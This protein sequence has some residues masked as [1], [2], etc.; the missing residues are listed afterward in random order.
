MQS[1]PD[2][3]MGLGPLTPG[4]RVA[5]VAPAG[6]PP[7]ALLERGAALL[8]DW[9]L[10]PV[11]FHS[12][13]ARHPRA[14]YLAGPD[15]RRAADLVAAWHD[16][17][18]TAIF[19]VRGGYGTVRVLD[20]LDAEAMATVAPKPVYGSSDITALHE[21]LR[22]RLDVPSWFAPM[23]ATADL[24][25]D[26]AAIASLRAAVFDG[27]AGRSWSAA[28][29][30]TLVPGRARGPLI[31]GNLSLLA[32]TIGARGRPAIH[33]AGAIALLED[34][35]EDVYR[36][37]GHLQTLVRAG[38]FDDI[39]GIALGSWRDCG[40]PEQIRA[41]M[42]ETLGPLGVPLAA[43][44]GFGHGPA[45]HSLPLGVPVTLAAPPEGTPSLCA[46]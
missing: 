21:W 10:V 42:V 45:A 24:L 39:A 32:M 17:S 35:T 43:D 8:R 31:G 6:P 15:A 5:L 19:C 37:D 23:I 38:W 1:V 25:D 26:A 20:L 46:G 34:V 3:A 16:P 11:I 9:G 36:L 44:L 14:D 40:P 22:E 13:L 28:T 29:A 41:L 4:D 12:A 2:I 7:A 33:N 30:R 27:P 18:I